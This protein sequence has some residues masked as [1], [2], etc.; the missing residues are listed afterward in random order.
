MPILHTSTPE[1][2]L[3]VWQDVDETLDKRPIQT[4][5]GDEEEVW[6]VLSGYMLKV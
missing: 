6:C 2:A 5:G 4:V 3:L 1:A